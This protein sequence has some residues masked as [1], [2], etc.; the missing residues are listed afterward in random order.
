MKVVEKKEE[1][2]EGKEEEEE[3]EVK[4]KRW[5]VRARTGQTFFRITYL[6]Y[7][8]STDVITSK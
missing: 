8:E 2:E 4:A 7:A 3:E 6:R 5:E 1:E